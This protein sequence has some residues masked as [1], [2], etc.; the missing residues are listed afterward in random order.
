MRAHVHATHTCMHA[1]RHAAA[2]ASTDGGKY[3]AVGAGGGAREREGAAVLTELVVQLLSR[4]RARRRQLDQPVPQLGREP[5]Q[6]R[7]R[8]QQLEHRLRSQRR[9][10][11]EDETWG[12]VA[13]VIR[14]G[15]RGNA[16]CVGVWPCGSKEGRGGARGVACLC[17]VAMARLLRAALAERAQKRQLEPRAGAARLRRRDRRAARQRAEQHV[18]KELVRAE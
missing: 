14:A 15:W 6:Q 2:R 7:R 9:T 10:R 16:R 13:A 4:R 1:K 8:L 17:C 18:G 11:G 12:C 3:A 5:L